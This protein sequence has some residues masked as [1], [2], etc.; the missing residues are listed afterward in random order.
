MI[1]K[2]HAEVTVDAKQRLAI[3]AKFRNLFK[4]DASTAWVAMPWRG[5]VLM[6]YPE[7][8]FDALAESRQNSLGPSEDQ[9]DTDADFY[10]LAER[11]E[12]D[13]AGR[14]TL[15]KLH[16]DLSKLGTDVIVVGAGKRLEIRDRATW[17]AELEKRYERLPGMMQKVDAE[18]KADAKKA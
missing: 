17:L 13:S 15:P 3:P 18:M 16:L 9:S 12:M 10:G 11:L 2:G 8:R 1:F 5:Q 14:V 6:L 7:T 4:G